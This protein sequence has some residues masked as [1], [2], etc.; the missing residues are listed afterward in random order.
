M[1]PC[2]EDGVAM[3][4]NFKSLASKYLMNASNVEAGENGGFTTINSL[5]RAFASLKTCMIRMYDSWRC[6]AIARVSAMAA[7]PRD[8]NF[9]MDMGTEAMPIFH[10]PA[11][12]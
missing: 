3:P 12:R 11:Y 7:G 10:F 2:R 6:W 8:A 1:F 4:F 5:R 9:S